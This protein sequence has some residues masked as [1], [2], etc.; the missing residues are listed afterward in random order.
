VFEATATRGWR[1]GSPVV[2]GIGQIKTEVHRT[3]LRV[4]LVLGL[5]L[6]VVGLGIFARVNG[7]L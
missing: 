2:R 7:F 5:M 1:V 6:Q 3:C 4:L